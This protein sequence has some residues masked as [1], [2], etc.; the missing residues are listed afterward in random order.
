MH[1]NRMKSSSSSQAMILI[2]SK[3]IHEDSTASLLEEEIQSEKK[4]TE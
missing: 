4:T 2:T 3:D 1:V